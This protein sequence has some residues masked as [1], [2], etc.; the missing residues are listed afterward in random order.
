MKQRLFKL[1]GEGKTKQV[2][3]ELL[4]ITQGQDDLHQE[5]IMQSSRFEEYSKI[6]RS[7]ITN[8][9]EETVFLSRIN[10]ALLEI[11]DKLPEKVQP[12]SWKLR[13]RIAGLATLVAI[14]G[15]IIWGLITL[16]KGDPV[17]SFSVT[18]LVHGKE[19]RDDLI[20]RNQGKV[21][22]DFGSARQEASIN[23]KREATL[24]NCPSG[25][26]EKSLPRHRSPPTLLPYKPRLRLPTEKDASIYLEVELLGI[27]KIHGRVLDFETQN[28]LDS[29]RV[30]VQNEA[31]YSDQFG[32]FELHIPPEIQAKFLKVTFFR[33]KY[34]METIDSIAPH[35]QAE[36]G[37]LLKKIEK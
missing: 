19:G 35:T 28:P 10:K 22:L 13:Q 3:Q 18:V 33:E 25:L 36:F 12:Q 17:D 27:N 32:W 29:V 20:L 21:V 1:L 4:R 23:E 7:G 8:L 31:T 14:I 24:R 26:L 6:K 9:E 34:K 30:S 16:G 11:I 15:G 37:I 5:V 2:I